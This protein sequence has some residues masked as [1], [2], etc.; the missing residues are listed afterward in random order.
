MARLT[1]SISQLGLG[2][3]PAH[4]AQLTMS[5]SQLGLGNSPIWISLISNE[6]TV[7][8]TPHQSRLVQVY[9]TS[10]M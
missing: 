7:T 5:I 6:V 9:Y 3:S 1:M 10:T 8:V 2:N 4:M